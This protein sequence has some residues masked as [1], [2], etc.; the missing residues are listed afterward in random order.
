[1]S[2]SR[3]G[4]APDEERRKWQNPE[5][6]LSHIGV[7]LGQ[8]FVDVGCGEGYFAIP[9]ARLV[10]EMGKVYGIDTNAEAI[11]RLKGKMAAENLTNLDLATGKAEEWVACEACADIVFFGTVLHD[12]ADPSQV[13]ANA[14]KMIKPSGLLIDLDWKKESM[15]WGPPLSI[16][17][18]EEHSSQLIEAA[19]FRAEAPELSGPF[20]YMIVARL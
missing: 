20:H 16:R 13:L 14:R 8:S 2:H 15:T 6:I 11:R 17:F 5:A 10:G 3:S 12:F 1:M 19:G 4:W 7:R 18:S 9:A